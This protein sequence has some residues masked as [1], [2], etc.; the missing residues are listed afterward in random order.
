VHGG[1]VEKM[2]MLRDRYLRFIQENTPTFY[3]PMHKTHNIKDKLSSFFGTQIYTIVRPN[4]RSDLVF[5][6]KENIGEA[7]QV[8]FDSSSSEKRILKDAARILHKYIVDNKIN[9]PGMPW[10]PSTTFLKFNAIAPPTAL[11]E[12][13]AR[14]ITGLK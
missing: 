13:I 4:G 7:V 5:S 10:P 3:N 12:F 14:V 6:S 8:A 9:S 2:T 11:T 1:N